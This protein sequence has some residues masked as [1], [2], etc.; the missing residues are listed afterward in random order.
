MTFNP[1]RYEHPYGIHLLDDIHN[2]F[3][4]FLYDPSMFP[5]SQ[6]I[7][8][9]QLRTNEL[10]SEE[11]SHNRSQYRLYQ[12][13]RRRREAGI[14]YIPHTP[15][16]R[17]QAIPMQTMGQQPRQP[18]QPIH[19]DPIRFQ[20]FTI[21]L[22]NIVGEGYDS[23]DDNDNANTNETNAVQ[24]THTTAAVNALLTTLLGHQHLTDLLAP[25][26]VAPTQEQIDAASIVSGVEP[27]ADVTCAI[28]QD[29]NSTSNVWRILRH[30]NHRF[31]RACID[32][33]FRQNVHC[34]VCRHDIREAEL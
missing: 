19:P 25:V 32:E 4:E 20:S 27:P 14:P 28:C 12:L 24:Q 30:C 11:Y 31:H 34:P 9:L 5:G 29:H 6:L 15:V 7:A 33:W 3:P 17:I 22:R 2:L 23:D 26:V 10:F 8:F 18:R 21:P 16:R 13:N 1:N